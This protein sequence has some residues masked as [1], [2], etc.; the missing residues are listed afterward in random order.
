MP[1][2]PL[3]ASVQTHTHTLSNVRNV[4]DTIPYMCVR[5][6]V[7]FWFV[8]VG[9]H[10]YTG[11]LSMFTTWV[12]VVLEALI[13]QTT[14]N[15]SSLLPCIRL[16]IRR[17]VVSLWV[18]TRAR[19][20][21][22]E[23]F[24]VCWKHLCLDATEI[25]WQCI[26]EIYSLH[27]HTHKN[28]MSDQ[29]C[30]LL[31]SVLK[32]SLLCSHYLLAFHRLRIYFRLFFSVIVIEVPA[33]MSSC[34]CVCVCVYSHAL[35]AAVSQIT[36]LHPCI[37]PCKYGVYVCEYMCVEYSTAS[38]EANIC[39]HPSIY[40]SAMDDSSIYPACTRTM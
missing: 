26:G 27:T 34:L 13:W 11:A 18:C 12:Y 23:W 33:D 3:Y 9:L 21:V 32:Y 35:D 2:V 24:A 16:C 25:H 40:I 38:A 22:L 36:A 15:V 37:I 14:E 7:F 8:L 1:F 20:M 39:I 10:C 4:Y 30:E 29:Q 5:V 17:V 19:K 6:C 31:R 28:G